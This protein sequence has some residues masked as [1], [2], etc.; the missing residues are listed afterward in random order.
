MA[1]ISQV[2][3]IANTL[4]PAGTFTTVDVEPD[5]AKLVRSA[6]VL[7]KDNGA[8]SY[9]DIRRATPGEIHT[10]FL[11]IAT[12]RNANNDFLYT[13]DDIVEMMQPTGGTGA[14]KERY[15][16]YGQAL[17]W[18]AAK[19]VASHLLATIPLQSNLK[20]YDVAKDLKET[21]IEDVERIIKLLD[22]DVA[23]PTDISTDEQGQ[24]SLY[25]AHDLNLATIPESSFNI[26]D[27]SS[28]SVPLSQ[29][30]GPTYDAPVELKDSV[31]T[32]R[33][34][35]I[36]TGQVG[37]CYFYMTGQAIDADK[38][39]ILAAN[40]VNNSS[41][42]SYKIEDVFRVPDNADIDTIITLVSDAINIKTLEVIPNTAIGNILVGPERG[43]TIARPQFAV[44]GEL[45]PETTSLKTR[46]ATFDLVYRVNRLN[47]EVRRSSSKV[48]AELL[49]IMFYTVDEASWNTY[50]FD[51]NVSNLR[52]SGSFGIKGLIFGQTQNYSSLSTT[53]PFSVLLKVDKGSV[54]PVSIQSDQLGNGDDPDLSADGNL[55]PIDSFYFH[56]PN[57]HAGF[58]KNLVLRVSST[59]Y[60]AKSPDLIEVDLVNPPI[61]P[62]PIIPGEVR[63]NEWTPPNCIGEEVAKRVTEA[64]YKY[65]RVTNTNEDD[66]DNTNILAVHLGEYSLKTRRINESEEEV[67]EINL[68]NLRTDNADT[69]EVE[70]KMDFDAGR[71]QIVGFKYKSREFKIVV[72]IIQIPSELYVATGNYKNRRTIWVKGK[73]R[74]ITIE[75]KVL[76]PASE[77]VAETI[78]QQLN[79]VKAS[80]GKAS[81]SN[82]PLLQS[83]YDKRK[84]LRESLRGFPNRWHDKY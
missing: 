57:S 59:A 7:L 75:T 33:G 28:S 55:L 36:P 10:I 72:D 42:V 32:H 21:A 2:Q 11:R 53:S 56:A 77:T 13:A 70:Y 17:T 23:Q 50:Q 3:L 30:N 68:R 47:F 43:Q 80:V 81:A 61:L 51:N 69:N 82:S 1:N 12:G 48:T 25:I 31:F 39:A 64:I 26:P 9:E 78:S 65:T 6:S 67:Y 60:G 14:T 16:M 19:L 74:S 5:F 24:I 29:Q 22:N 49:T 41:S 62:R 45:Y 66:S 79:S 44:K 58:S 4:A 73:P 20:F 34:V 18:A 38:D 63:E 83:V 52:N 76:N 40:E 15:N 35:E 27:T 84:L 71:V 8:L 54:I 37:F 46:P